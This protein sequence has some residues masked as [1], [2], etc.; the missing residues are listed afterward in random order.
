MYKFSWRSTFREN[1][2]KGKLNI[3]AISQ[4]NT[5]PYFVLEEAWISH[6]WDTWDFRAGAQLFDW[7]IF[8]VFKV[9]D[10][11][12]RVHLPTWLPDS[13]EDPDKYGELSLSVKQKIGNSRLDIRSRKKIT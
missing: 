13:A 5:T 1:K 4:S 12:N 8:D 2:L 9:S 6:S 3:S 7:S 11:V 10:I